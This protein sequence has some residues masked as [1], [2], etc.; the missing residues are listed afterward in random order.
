M[1]GNYRMAAQLV[2][3]RVALSST[4]LGV[5]VDGHYQLV[6]RIWPERMTP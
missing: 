5:C 1:L 3:S 6:R 2:T 4:E